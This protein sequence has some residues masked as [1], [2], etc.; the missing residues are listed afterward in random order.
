M[1]FVVRRRVW[2][3]E[4]GTRVLGKKGVPQCFLELLP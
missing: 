4:Y 1:G 3:R 2:Y